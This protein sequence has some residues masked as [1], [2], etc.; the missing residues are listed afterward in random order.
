MSRPERDPEALLSTGPQDEGAAIVVS[1]HHLASRAGLSML[2]RGGNAID[3][4]IAVDAVLG[5][6]APDTCGPG[7]DLFAMI[8]EP[9]SGGPATLNASGRAGSGTSADALR[10]AG[11]GEI[12]YRSPWSI[13]VPGC[14]DGWEALVERFANLTLAECL[15]PAIAIAR[16]GFQ[17][18]SELAAS[19]SLLTD[20]I[21]TQG[22]ST[23]L[24]PAG[25]PAST[26]MQITRP[27]LSET[28]EA[29]ASGGRAAFYGGAVGREI[30]AA[31]RGAVT[32][33]DLAVTQSEWVTP[34][35]IDIFGKTAWTIGTNT[36]GYLTLATLWMFEHL[37]PPTD[38]N[39][40]LFHHLLI[41]AY[42]SVAWERGMYVSDPTTAPLT[43]AQL[44]DVD[45]LAARA[46]TIDRSRAGRWP[47]PVPAP[48]GTA[49][50]TVR[51]GSGMGVSFIQSN[52]AGIGSGLSA[53]S[54]GV[55]LHNRGAG[56]NLIPGHPNE[57]TPGNRPMHTL[58]PT[59]WSD[60]VDLE[61]L[62][63]T[64]GGDQ[65]P[66]F[67]AQYAAHHFHAG[68]CTD[69]SQ[70][71]PRWNM[72]QPRPGTDST[73]RI[74]PRFNPRTR[75]TLESMGHA[76]EDAEAWEPGWGPISAIDVGGEMKGSADPRISTSAALHL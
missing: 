72:E 14:V 68:S 30:T 2:E 56:F 12:P 6:V 10:E 61:L 17:V 23:S 67:L 18:S 28:L 20:L 54:T 41:E 32:R 31:T 65:Q 69:D 49:Y 48:G 4:A 24:Y 43:N 36:Q 15:E 66:Q 52:F 26:G 11:Y 76:I 16:D 51:D 45:R 29:I 64:R 75:A 34:A 57:Y 25:V 60:G 8:H 33:D 37:D 21:A 53:G 50:M 13:T 1:P 59:L 58:S 27:D 40:P 38:A 42:R 9:G 39:D 3:A 62:L 55:F 7:G 46:A 71:E 5:V 70:M 73:L 35:S 47:M 63:G 74:E 44:L 22:S 19:L